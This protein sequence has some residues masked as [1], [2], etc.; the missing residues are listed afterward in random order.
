MLQ[1]F[2]PGGWCILF[3]SFATSKKV[4]EKHI[5]VLSCVISYILLSLLSLIRIKFFKNIPNNA[6]TNSALSIIIGSAI[7]LI[8]SVL[9]TRKWFKQWM[10]QIFHKT[11]NSDI[12]RDVFD[13]EKGSN[14]KVYIKNSDYYIIGHFKSIEEKGDNSWLALSAFAKFDKETNENYKSEPAFLNNEDV[15]ITVRLS[16]VGHIEI[17]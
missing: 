12:W 11:P 4:N 15:I 16:D 1:Y 6:I 14:V 5:L 9:F 8:I 7:V 17:F 2:I 10:V 3:F 13:F